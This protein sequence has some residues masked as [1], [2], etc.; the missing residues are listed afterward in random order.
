MGTRINLA[1][2]S[3]QNLPNVKIPA[4]GNVGDV[5]TL[6]NPAT[7]AG[8][9]MAPSIPTP[10]S[11]VLWLMADAGVF[12]DAGV[13]PAVNTDPVYQWNDQ[14]GQGN[15]VDQVTLGLR[16]IYNTNVQNGLP[17]IAF[18][19]SYM[20]NVLNSLV[21]QG[22]AYTVVFAGK[23]SN[24]TGGWFFCIRSS[25]LLSASGIHLSGNEY[26]YED[27]VNPPQSL[28]IA[29]GAYKTSPFVQINKYLGVGT[30]PIIRVQGVARPIV[31]GT[32]QGNETGNVGF[33][34]GVDY[35]SAQYWPGDMYEIM[36]FNAALTDAQMIAEET[37]L[38]AKW[39]L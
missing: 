31:V 1:G 12:S 10:S 25:Y 16:P 5:W 27:A 37:R 21:A 22:S 32:T 17:A 8:A 13:T 4:G 34:V 36:V 11:L 7:G 29:S 39:S 14:S 18:S 38:T 6:T 20:N 2:Q 26:V 19:S 28:A 30:V 24:A 15:N 35:L 33:I 9:W 3:D 23:S